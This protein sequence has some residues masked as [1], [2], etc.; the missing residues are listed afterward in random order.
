MDND[1]IVNLSDAEKTLVVEKKATCPFIAGAVNTDLLPV[2]N[3]AKDPLAAIEDVRKLGNT[4]GGDLGDL[5]KHFAT[6]NHAFM[7]GD[8]GRLSK[9]VPDDLFSLD[10]PGSQGSH[11][12]HSGILQ[13]DPTVLES[14]RLSMP[15]FNRLIKRA[16]NGL[17]K[18]SDFGHFIAENLKN[19]PNSR[20]IGQ[21]TVELV[22]DVIDGALD[23]FAS[24]G[25]GVME[26][27]FGDDER[28][29]THR[30]I[31]KNITGLAAKNNLVGSAGEFGLLFAFLANSPR[32][33]TIDG[34]LALSVE[35]LT[36]MF[37]N[38]RLPVGWEAWEKSWKDWIKHT[39][40]LIISTELAYRT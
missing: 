39:T 26:Y 3:N 6:G 22:I 36:E 29:D 19:D 5:L 23:T 21:N 17:I 31:E 28:D 14:G 25:L 9:E 18:R 33:K 32:S 35:D 11:P 16:Q 30:L 4:G 10:F 7:R 20:T 12:G 13:G 40:G 37:V 27:L 1:N 24:V 15:D 2:R 34:E 38:K 8:D